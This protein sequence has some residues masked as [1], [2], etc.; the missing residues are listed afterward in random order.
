MLLRK[1]TQPIRSTTKYFYQATASTPARRASGP[2][3]ATTSARLAPTPTLSPVTL[4][5]LFRVR[6]VTSGTASAFRAAP[7]PPTPSDMFARLAATLSES[8]RP[9]ALPRPPSPALPDTTCTASTASPT[10]SAQRWAHGTL[11]VSAASP[12]PRL[13]IASRLTDTPERLRRRL[14]VVLAEVRL[15]RHLYGG[16]SAVMV[17]PLG[18]VW[19]RVTS[20]S[21]ADLL[22]FVQLERPFQSV[23]R[24]R[25][26]N[27]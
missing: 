3:R 7:P 1:L 2:T 12:R 5:E 22:S 23:S 11:R 9:F 8:A 27:C 15:R 17:R 20:K 25:F 14:L 24:L 6:A 13:R 21:A 4:R 10:P 18:S 19:T 16:P 26:R